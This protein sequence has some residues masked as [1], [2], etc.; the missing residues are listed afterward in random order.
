VKAFHLQNETD[1]LH[2]K[3]I[4]NHTDEHVIPDGLGADF[5]VRGAIDRKTN[6][7]LG[8]LIDQDLVTQLAPFRSFLGFKTSRNTDIIL[9]SADGTIQLTGD[10]P[11]FIPAKGAAPWSATKVD[12][13]VTQL[14]VEGL[15]LEQVQKRIPH[16]LAAH[17]VPVSALKNVQSSRVRTNVGGTT[18]GTG[19]GGGGFFR[20]IAKSSLI[21]LSRYAPVD[22][23]LH[24]SFGPLRSYILTDTEPYPKADL[25]CWDSRF[26]VA[27]FSAHLANAEIWHEIAL[28][29]DPRTGI[30]VS[31]V[32]LFGCLRVSC[33]LTT[34][35]TGS[36]VSKCLSV[37]LLRP[38]GAH[39]ESD[40]PLP[41]IS[42]LSVEA[43]LAHAMDVPSMAAAINRVLARCDVIRMERYRDTRKAE[44]EA[45]VARADRN[46]ISGDQ[47]Q[48][49][50]MQFIRS[51]QVD[52]GV[53]PG[54]EEIPLD[55]TISDLLKP[56]D[57]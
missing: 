4:E 45:L 55:L 50:L 35:W 39:Q 47:F 13:Q 29:C 46:E 15:S 2:L 53:G 41:A 19:F 6:N 20:S 1:L 32:T 27:A 42:G 24:E 56:K 57:A 12:G 38:T 44:L 18:I 34:T 14:L 26:G 23:L 25:C 54:S 30:A 40:E 48:A 37:D 33:L 51:L 7:D 5:V 10:K 3:P 17:R 11:S 22:V 9:T 52:L 49:L 16:M 21:A 36:D 31:V 8:K 43:W 28:R